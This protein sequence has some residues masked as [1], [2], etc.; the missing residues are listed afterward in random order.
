MQIG[1]LMRRE[2]RSVPSSATFAEA[3]ALLREH[4]ISSVVVL[5]D[6]RLSGIVT[7]RDLVNLVASGVD[8]KTT[9]VSH[10][11][12]SNVDTA[13]PRTDVLEA[14]AVMGKRKIRHLPV[15]QEG[16]VVGIVSIR[17]LTDWAI[18]ELT[19]GHELPDIERSHAALA[20]AAELERH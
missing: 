4:G 15:V 11:M 10:G 12:S 20:A 13:E 5:D 9:P 7:E 8:P 17:D 3:A 16:S 1:D 6:G 19:A 14:A 2:V 18:S